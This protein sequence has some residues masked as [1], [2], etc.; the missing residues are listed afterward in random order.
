MSIDP[1]TMPMLEPSIV[2]GPARAPVSEALQQRI[3]AAIRT[4]LSAAF[5]DALAVLRRN[6]ALLDRGSEELM[7]RETLDEAA[8]GTYRAALQ[9]P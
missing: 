1:Q 4:I 2:M 7:Q 9:Q 8:I 3:D 6:R 5:D